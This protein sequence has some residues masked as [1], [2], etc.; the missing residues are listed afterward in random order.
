[1][2]ESVEQ[3]G[4]SFAVNKIPPCGRF[5]TW[6]DRYITNAGAKALLQNPDILKGSINFLSSKLKKNQD[7]FFLNHV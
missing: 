1:M 5:K 7:P 2:D 4:S 3:I 6:R